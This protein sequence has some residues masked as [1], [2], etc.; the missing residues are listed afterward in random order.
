M[1][2]SSCV[3]LSGTSVYS[4]AS[5]SR[6]ARALRLLKISSSRAKLN[7]LCQHRKAIVKIAKSRSACDNDTSECSRPRCSKRSMEVHEHKR[8]ANHAFCAAPTLLCTRDGWKL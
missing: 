5:S 4:W 3:V 7:V 2:P 1:C 6:L 8:H